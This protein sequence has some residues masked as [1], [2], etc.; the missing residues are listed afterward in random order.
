MSRFVLCGLLGLS[1]LSAG[2]AL[3]AEPD[4]AMLE[5]GKA[6][7]MKDAVPACAVCH[8][9]QDAGAAGPI[10]PD[11]DELKPTLE[12]VKKVLVEGA[13]TMPSFAETLDEASRE[14]VAA[15]VVHAT[16]G[17]K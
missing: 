10:G 2:P 1:L 3:A 6:L 7:F 4:A 9:L 14:A 15:Y 13:G 17:G 11:L 8:T 5:K 12:Q 16:G